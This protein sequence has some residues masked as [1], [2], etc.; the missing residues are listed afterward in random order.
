MAWRPQYEGEF[1]FQKVPVNLSHGAP[2]TTPCP[3]V[4]PPAGAWH[5]VLGAAPTLEPGDLGALGGPELTMAAA[6]GWLPTKGDP[7]KENA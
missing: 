6:G 5:P 4:L 3:E 2:G 7:E 1:L